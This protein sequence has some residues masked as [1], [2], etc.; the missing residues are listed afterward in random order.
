M[1][2]IKRTGLNLHF[3]AMIAANEIKWFNADAAVEE[4][5]VK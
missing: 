1:G 5:G 2:Q 3:Q 4:G